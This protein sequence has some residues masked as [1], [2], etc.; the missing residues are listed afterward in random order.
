MTF[1]PRR[2]DVEPGGTAQFD[3]FLSAETLE[4][5]NVASVLPA[6]NDL[7]ILSF[8]YAQSWIDANALPLIP[9]LATGIFPSDLFFG[10][11]LSAPA[12]GS[13]LIGT[14]TVGAGG[15][16]IGE[17]EVFVDSSRDFGTSSI[18]LNAEFETLSGSAL[19]NVVPEPMTF[20]L[21]GLGALALLRRRRTA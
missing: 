12:S 2:V 6:S 17:Y 19:V 7:Q 20:S 21:L 11:F 8:D 3:L 5:F 16:D 1:D 18:G 10:G 9:P 13:V 14:L 4:S 15:L